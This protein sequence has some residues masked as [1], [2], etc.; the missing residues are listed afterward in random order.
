MRIASALIATLALVTLAGC[1]A[2]DD[3]AVAVSDAAD[4]VTAG[5]DEAVDAPAAP[6]EPPPDEDTTGPDPA[7]PVA[8]S[9]TPP[10]RD[11]ILT[12]QV[13]VRADDVRSAASEATQRVTAAGGFL[14]GE[15]TTYDGADPRAVLT[16]KIPPDAFG[17]VVAE[18][19]QVGEIVSQDTSAE[20]VTDRIVDLRS[21]IDT[22]E[23][24]VD[25][26]RGF[27]AEAAGVEQVAAL[28]RELLDR[29][30]QLEQLR[31]QLRSLGD[32]VA[33][34]TVTVT[35]TPTPEDPGELLAAG[36]GD[37]V[38]FADGLRAGW[39]ALVTVGTGVA[40]V[41]GAVL[42][43]LPVVLMLGA[44]AWL[45]ERRRRRPRGTVSSA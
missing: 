10:G 9:A 4:S 13:A 18:L 42:P 28:E 21:R 3:D 34:S 24:S 16:F 17:V 31:G 41:T 8:V 40:V 29:E 32:R 38:T 11:V 44:G 1:T 35:I 45:I 22:A 36:A 12:A 2:G 15:T 33:L 27:L 43:W 6:T 30:T 20:D 5:V 14:F 25:R 23:V 37:D 7:L 39:S 26:L 19:G